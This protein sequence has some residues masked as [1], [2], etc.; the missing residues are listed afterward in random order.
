LLSFSIFRL[1][2][3]VGIGGEYAAINSAVDELIPG[4]LREQ[5]TSSSTAPFGSALVSGL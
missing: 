3:G 2:T 4:K 1:V 5:W